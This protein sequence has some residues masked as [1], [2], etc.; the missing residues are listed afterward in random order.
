MNSL[1]IAATDTDAG[2]TVVTT[3][4]VAYWQK[5]YPA[6]ALGLMKLM[7]TGQ[8][9][10]EWYEGLFQGQL[11]MITPLQYQA[12]LAPPVAADLEGRDIPLGTVWQALLNLQK[13]QDLVL[14]EGLGGLGCPVTHELTLA[15]LAA[16]WRLKTLLVVPVKLGAISQTVANIALAEQKKV[17]LGG[18]ILNCLEPRTETEIEQLTPINLIQSLTNCP[19]LGVFPFIEDRRDLDKLASVVASWPEIKLSS[20]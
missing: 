1:L 9:D 7:Q 11:E 4:L 18:I 2:K 14:I 16:Q 13:S 6:K 8:G 20:I 3:A 10:R 5:Y 12:P 19:V 15:D 17:N